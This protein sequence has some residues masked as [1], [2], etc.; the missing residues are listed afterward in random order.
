MPDAVQKFLIQTKRKLSPL[1]AIDLTSY[2]PQSSDAQM[3]LQTLLAAAE[4]GDA[5]A[6]CICA[7]CYRSGWGTS[8]DG[9]KAFFWAKKSAE[10]EFPPGIAELG[11]CYEEGIGTEKNISAALETLRGASD[12]GY[13]M[14]ALH[15]AVRFASGDP[16]GQLAKEALNYAERAYELGDPYAAHL[17]GS[18]F[19]GGTLFPKDTTAAR[20]WYEKA[21]VNGSRLASLRL[22][23]AYKNGELGL[24]YDLEKASLFLSLCESGTHP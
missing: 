20:S 13:S 23:T 18:W 11:Y 17:L 15:L 7:S 4:E 9:E 5:Y 1:Q 8:V 16:Y 6:G 14:A 10:T 12:A 22:F 2:L 19:E 21:A 24:P 3:L